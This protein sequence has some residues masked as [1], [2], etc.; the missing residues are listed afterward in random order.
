MSNLID[1]AKRE[2]ALINE[3]PEFV[4][5]YLKIVEIFAGMGHSGG[6]AEI[7]ATVIHQLLQQQNLYP[8][9][10]DPNEWVFQSNEKYGLPEDAW[11]NGRGGI[12]QNTRLGEAFS[13]DGG[14]SYY[15]LCETEDTSKPSIIH[16]SKKRRESGD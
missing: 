8:L 14:K 13:S 1:H 3:E 4:E 6:S 10:D 11:N 5:A 16:K 15:L 12:W 7:A 2:L 9:T